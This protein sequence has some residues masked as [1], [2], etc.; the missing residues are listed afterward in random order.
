ML[1]TK[2]PLLLAFNHPN[3]F[4]DAIILD[5][6]FDQPVWSLARGDAFK[7][8]AIS[9]I[10]RSFRILPVYRTSE[11][12]EKLSEN[13]KT[14]DACI[15]IFQ[16]DGCVQIFSEGR[17]VNEWHLRPLK[18]GTA[19]LANMAWDNNIPLRVLPLGINYSSFERFGKNVFINFGDFIHS[20]DIDLTASDGVRNQV[21][22]NLL[23]EQL[24]GLIYEIDLKDKDTQRRLLVREPSLLKKI[25][26]ALPAAIGFIL[27]APLYLP[28]RSFVKQKAGG[29]G[30]YDSVMLGILMIVYPFYLLLLVLIAYLVTGSAWSWLLMLVG[31]FTAWSY[32][33][34]KEQLDK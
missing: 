19:R 29:T 13:Y 1:K 8:K 18:K 3:S 32:V 27:N 2:G 9:F 15:E 17:C 33:Q 4:L 7:G 16:E 21:F 14:F 28:I 26:L 34:L 5:I 24:Q 12:T 6:L 11:G 30:H 25:I 10:L 23:Q 20:S 31:P 22:N